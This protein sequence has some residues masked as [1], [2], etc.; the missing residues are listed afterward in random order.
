MDFFDVL[1]LIGGLCLFLFGMNTMSDGLEKLAG[2]KLEAILKKMTSN[3]VKS[4]VL[5]AGI[6]AVIQS[7]SAVTVMLVGLV[8]SGLM[9]MSQTLYVIYGANIGTT[10]TAWIT[11]LAFMEGGGNFFLWL[12]DTDTLAPI[13]LAIGIIL[14]M[15]IKSKKSKT[16][17]DI[18][19]GFGILFIGLMNMTGAVKG[20]ADSPAFMEILASFSDTPILGILAGLVLTVIVQSSSATVG[21]LQTVAQASNGAVTFAMAYPVIMGINL[22]TCV[23][24]AMVCSIGSSKDAKRTGVVHI[25]FN[26][27]GTIVFMGVMYVLQNFNVWGEAFWFMNA[28]SGV[29]ANFQTIFNLVTAIA[30]IPF[31][32]LLVKLSLAI[33]KPE[34][35]VKKK[36]A[37]QNHY[38]K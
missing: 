24:T 35:I 20:F 29:I 33:V 19:M 22:G 12:F 37:N 28:D 26:V 17:G 1:N 32:G 2:G 25:V 23:T 31:A 16:I 10:V 27:I 9:T 11:N 15:F 3:P 18:S 5:G 30:L 8:N 38:Q 13:A 6:T 21:M 36:N 4:L 14:I 34:K 7:S